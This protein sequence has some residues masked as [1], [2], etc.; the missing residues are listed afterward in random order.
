[1]V[2]LDLLLVAKLAASAALPRL[3]FSGF[4]AVP[5]AQRG[6]TVCLFLVRGFLFAQAAGRIVI[7]FDRYF[8]SNL[9]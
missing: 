4:L 9:C 1:M 7:K 6:K 8:G 2:L 5:L 3:H